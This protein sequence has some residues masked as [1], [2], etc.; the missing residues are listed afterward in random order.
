MKKIC[1]F[2]LL[3]AFAVACRKDGS[4]SGSNK[5]LL[6]KLFRGG[7]LETEFIYNTQGKL[8]RLNYYLAGVGLSTLSS[9]RLFDYNDDGKISQVVSFSKEHNPTGKRV[10]TYSAQGKL[11]RIDEASAFDADD[12]LDNIDFFEVYNYNAGGQLENMTRRKSNYAMHS[13]TDFTY[14]DKG[15]LTG[16]ESWY[17]DNGDLVLKQKSEYVP[18]TKVMPDHWKAFLT[19]PTDFS[20]HYLFNA[21]Q[22]NTTYWVGELKTDWT[23]INRQYNSQGYVTSQTLHIEYEDGSTGSSDF[24]Y[25]YV[26]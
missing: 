23:F 1:C 19:T 21:A 4:G 17:Q 13:S 3:A 15:N 7:L 12:D 2:I 20:L 25:E 26:Q 14:D 5:L 10:F 9:Y 8:V 16:E 24:S 18:G 22:N 6:S 11:S